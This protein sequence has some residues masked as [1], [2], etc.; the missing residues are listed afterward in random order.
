L[1][2]TTI[3]L[4]LQKQN[5]FLMHRGRNFIYFWKKSQLSLEQSWLGFATIFFFLS[6]DAVPAIKLSSPAFEQI[7]FSSFKT[8]FCVFSS[9]F[10]LRIR[11]VCALAVFQTAF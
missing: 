3:L 6:L 4:R 7:F 10:V 1:F 8:A 2:F 11:C 9:L 5:K